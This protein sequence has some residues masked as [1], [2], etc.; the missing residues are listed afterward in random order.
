MKISKFVL[1]CAALCLSAAVVATPAPVKVGWAMESIDPGRSSVMP[2]YGSFRYSFGCADPIYATCLVLDN[3]KDAVI[4]VS[5]DVISSREILPEVVA[6]AKKVAPELPADK[7]FI[8]ATHTHSSLNVYYSCQGVP[9]E[10][11]LMSG[12][13]IRQIIL[14]TKLLKLNLCCRYGR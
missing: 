10:F 7:F 9:K 8:N 13:E 4:F 11:N 5:M 3:G 6:E 2:G 14:L 1:A 12:K